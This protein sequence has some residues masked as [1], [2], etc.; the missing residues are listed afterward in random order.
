MSSVRHCPLPEQL[1]EFVSIADEIS[2]ARKLQVQFHL[3]RCD[4]CQTTLDSLQ[5]QWKAALLPEMD[6]TRSLLS[7]YGR[8]QRDETLILKGWKLNTARRP[9][10]KVSTH[11]L[12]EGW[13]FRGLI[14]TGLTIA[15]LSLV[16]RVGPVAQPLRQER[17]PLAQIRIKEKDR[18]KVHYVEPELLQSMEFETTGFSR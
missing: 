15:V 8:L 9:T 14:L 13:V 17:T 7:V 3:W 4:R 10:H 6:T 2:L 12:R 5:Q 16:F 18:V 11:L 1:L